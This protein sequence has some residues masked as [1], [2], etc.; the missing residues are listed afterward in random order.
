[1]L[2]LSPLLYNLPMSGM[3][4]FKGYLP[5]SVSKPKPSPGPIGETLTYARWQSADIDGTGKAYVLLL[6]LC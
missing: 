3:T 5:Q 4:A 6:A 1:M 2:S